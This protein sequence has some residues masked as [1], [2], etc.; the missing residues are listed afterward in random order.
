MASDAVPVTI[1][2]ASTEDTTYTY[3]GSPGTTSE[4]VVTSPRR[5]LLDPAIMAFLIII[6]QALSAAV[7]ILT[8]DE[9]GRSENV[10][11]IQAREQSTQMASC[12]FCL[13]L[14]AAVRYVPLDVESQNIAT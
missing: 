8:G 13:S 11:C 7:G 12:E 4:L 10:A 1:S 2:P 5:S 9:Y 14:F 6:C 3:D